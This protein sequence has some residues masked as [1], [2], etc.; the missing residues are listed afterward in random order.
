MGAYGHEQT[1]PDGSV[2]LVGIGFFRND[3][4]EFHLTAEEERS[5]LGIAIIT[6]L[7]TL[8]ICCCCYLCLKYRGYCCPS[9]NRDEKQIELPDRDVSQSRM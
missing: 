7:F 1:Q 4:S 3:C 6:I 9:K 5:L 2:S 8:M